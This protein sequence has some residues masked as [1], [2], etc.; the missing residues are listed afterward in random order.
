MMDEV[1]L[2]G[3]RIDRNQ[4]KGKRRKKKKR[5][6]EEEGEGAKQLILTQH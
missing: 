6:E 3:G 2:E 1:L 5:R 4:Q